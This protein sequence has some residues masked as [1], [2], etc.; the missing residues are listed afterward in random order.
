M[1]HVTH[2]RHGGGNFNIST[3]PRSWD[4]RN[5]EGE[6]YDTPFRYQVT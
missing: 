3:F 2:S 1:D 6:N 5:V 4:W